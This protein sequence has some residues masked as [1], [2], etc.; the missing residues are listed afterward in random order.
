MKKN[1]LHPRNR[2]QAKDGVAYD[3]ALLSSH[4]PDLTPFIF[5]NNYGNKSIDFS[6]A[7]GVKELNK[8]L[9]LSFYDLNFWD[10]PEQYLCPPI[11]GRADYLHYIADLLAINFEGDIPTGKNIKGLDVGTGANLIYPIIGS[12]EYGWSFVGSDIDPTSINWAKQ[13]CKFNPRLSKHIKLRQQSNPQDIFHGLIN[14][15]DRFTFSM[16]NPPFHSSEQEANRGTRRKL[17]N[18]AAN[19]G[20]QVVTQSKLNFGGKNNELWCEGGETQF[21]NNM[22]EQS[23]DYSDQVLWFTSLVSKK[24]NLPDIYKALKQANAKQVKTID[25]GQGNKISRF[26]AWSYL[27]QEQQKMWFE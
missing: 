17:K 4:N 12:H 26:V 24:E 11:P 7:K 15:Q 6:D 25:M 16:C 10:I 3:F 20:D 22:I 1:P 19:R 23:Q 27:D 8:A 21:I 9:L 2:H 18:L 13:L 5:E 14:K